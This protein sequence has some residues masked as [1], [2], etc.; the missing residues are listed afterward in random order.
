MTK[1]EKKRLAAYAAQLAESTGFVFMPEFGRYDYYK[2]TLCGQLGLTIRDNADIRSSG[3]GCFM[4]FDEPA[5]ARGHGFHCNPHS[6]K[7]NY[8]AI[9]TINAID[10]IFQQFDIIS[11]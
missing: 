1:K 4:M 11:I 7:Y 6:G 5:K 9:E 2:K 8:H 3:I 10:G